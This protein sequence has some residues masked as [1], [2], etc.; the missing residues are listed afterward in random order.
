MDP[1]SAAL[2]KVQAY[3]RQIVAYEAEYAAE[4]RR[5]DELQAELRQARATILGYSATIDQAAAELR[6]AREELDRTR[7]AAMNSNLRESNALARIEQL[8]AALGR[9]VA[10]LQVALPYLDSVCNVTAHRMEQDRATLRAILADPTCA[11]AGEAWREFIDAAIAARDALLCGR[12]TIGANTELA[13]FR[14]D[15]EVAGDRLA[16]VLAKVDA[17]RGANG[18]SK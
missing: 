16:A 2:M 17:R 8:Q 9:A 15:H 12:E 4:K 5:A 6:Q 1:L 7:Q 14:T 11:A 13:A 3:E 10:A 18:G